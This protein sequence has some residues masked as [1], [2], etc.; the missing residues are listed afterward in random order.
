MRHKKLKQCSWWHMICISFCLSTPFV[1]F[2]FLGLNYSYTCFDLTFVSC[3]S[4]KINF[5]EFVTLWRAGL[6]LMLYLV[7]NC[8]MNILCFLYMLGNWLYLYS[9][10]LWHH[11]WKENID[12]PFLSTLSRFKR[13]N[14]SGIIYDVINWFAQIC[15]CN[16]C[17]N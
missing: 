14:G 11:S 13:T 12:T 5:V 9:V 1:D 17:N 7:E 4:T 15:R 6:V 16:F 2:E 8:N 3:L 10:W